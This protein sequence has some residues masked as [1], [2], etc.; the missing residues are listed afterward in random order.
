[1]DKQK[2]LKIKPKGSP[3]YHINFLLEEIAGSIDFQEWIK[4]AEIWLRCVTAT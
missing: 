4:K 3:P 2:E 1:M